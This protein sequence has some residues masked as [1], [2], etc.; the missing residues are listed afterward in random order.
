MGEITD[1]WEVVETG[2]QLA[3]LAEYPS[4]S[5]NKVIVPVKGISHVCGGS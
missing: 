3:A 5:L 1:I 2:E 4:I